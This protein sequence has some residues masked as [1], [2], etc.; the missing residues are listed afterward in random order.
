LPWEPSLTSSGQE[1]CY[2]N[3]YIAQIPYTAE[4]V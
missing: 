4:F 1:C 3:A 2:E